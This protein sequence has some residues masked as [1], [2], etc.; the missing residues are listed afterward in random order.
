L[1]FNKLLKLH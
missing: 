1:R